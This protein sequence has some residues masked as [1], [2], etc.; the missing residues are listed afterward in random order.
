MELDLSLPCLELGPDD[1]DRCVVMLHGFGANAF[2]LVPLAED[3]DLPRTRFVL[4]NAPI[5]PATMAGGLPLQAWYDIR[6]LEPS[7]DREDPDHIRASAQDIE[8]ILDSQRLAG[9]PAERT[10]LGGFSQGG[11]MALHVGLRHPHSLAA[12]VGLST[13]LVQP[14]DL[15]EQRHA[16]NRD[17]PLWLAHGTGD[18]VVPLARGQA[19]MEQLRRAGHPV[20][21]STWPVDHQLHRGEI[22]ALRD[23]L[24]Q[25]LAP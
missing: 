16:A 3:L 18:D 21:W 24:V 12:L 13:Y 6:T 9:I 22:E 23:F 5:I 19:S 14:E 1:A 7:P 20:H 25:R 11:A 10:V 8:R 4:P 2:D 17:T 15:A